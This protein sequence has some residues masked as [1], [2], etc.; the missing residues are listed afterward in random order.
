MSRRRPTI[1]ALRRDFA[2]RYPAAAQELAQAELAALIAT[3][4]LLPHPAGGFLM[5]RV[6]H[7]AIVELL[8]THAVIR[9]LGV[10][11]LIFREEHDFIRR[12][13]D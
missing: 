4:A 7:P 3:A 10:S 12:V 5:P 8:R 13:S 9:R 2:R 11:P 1:A 6:Y